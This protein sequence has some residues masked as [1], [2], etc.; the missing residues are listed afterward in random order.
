MVRIFKYRGKTIEELKEMQLVELSELLPA[1]A[2][3][4]LK[5]GLQKNRKNYLRKSKTSR[6][7]K[8]RK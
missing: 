6:L 4:S 2:R 7:E 3:R 5:R 1:R 8:E